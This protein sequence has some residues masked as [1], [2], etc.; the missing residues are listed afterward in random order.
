[1][2]KCKHKHVRFFHTPFTSSLRTHEQ[3]VTEQTASQPRRQAGGPHVVC[4]PRPQRSFWTLNLNECTP[5]DPKSHS[6]SP[7][8]ISSKKK[9]EIQIQMKPLPL[10][11]PVILSPFCPLTQT[12]KRR[13]GGAMADKWGPARSSTRGRF[14]AVAERMDGWDG[15]TIQ[16][17]PFP[18][19]RCGDKQMGIC[20]FSSSVFFFFWIKK[21]SAPLN[22]TLSTQPFAVALLSFH[23]VSTLMSDDWWLS[24]SSLNCTVTKE[25]SPPHHPPSHTW[26]IQISKFKNRSRSINWPQGTK[27]KS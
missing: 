10:T 6:P 11:S 12:K 4:L 16:T 20:F 19:T 3:T 27:V 2:C 21:G 22:R 25:S 5:R 24:W 9:R 26:G 18:S 7:P 17:L 15:S 8:P 23:A 14:P 1:M 13:R